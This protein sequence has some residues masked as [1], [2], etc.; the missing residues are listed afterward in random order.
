MDNYKLD[1]T[2]FVEDIMAKSRTPLQQRRESKLERESRI[3]REHRVEVIPSMF[4]K[5]GSPEKNAA[6]AEIREK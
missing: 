2:A 1:E 4:F 6:F 5:P 3:E